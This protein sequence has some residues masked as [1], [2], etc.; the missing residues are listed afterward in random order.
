MNTIAHATG[1]AVIGARHARMARNGQDAVVTSVADGIAIGIVSDGCGSGASSEVGARLGATLFARVLRRTLE[2]GASVLDPATWATVRAEVIGVLGELIERLGGESLREQFLF[3]IVASAVT[4]EGAAV[5]AIGDGTYVLHDRTCVLGPFADNQ[6]PYLAYDLIGEPRLAHFAT[7]TAGTGTVIVA[8]DGA[9][10]GE[11]GLDA[12]AA[13]AFANPDA[14]RRRLALLARSG[15]VIEWDA[16]R[17]VRAPAVLQ[18]DCA[19]AV[20]RW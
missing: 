18:D 17:V 6:P 19:V 3:T 1:A 15:E 8:T 20:I 14:L 10:E 13:G 12:I 4:P 11:L 7:T 5:W 2:R 9:V 16:H